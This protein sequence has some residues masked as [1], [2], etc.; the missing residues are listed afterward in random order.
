MTDIL[1]PMVRLEA[2]LT[3]EVQRAKARGIVADTLLVTARIAAGDDSALRDLSHLQSQ[4]A[5]LAAAAAALTRD[6]IL[7]TVAVVVARILPPPV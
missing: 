2:S 5:S 6:A 4:T 3:D 1:D 7:D